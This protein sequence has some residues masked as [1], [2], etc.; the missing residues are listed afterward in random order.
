LIAGAVK[1]AL[2][3][4]TSKA[5]PKAEKPKASKSGKAYVRFEKGEKDG[6]L[7]AVKVWDGGG[8]RSLASL[9]AENWALIR[10]ALNKS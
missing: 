6:I 10:E 2:E 7:R 8:F 1:S 5:K 3:S 9:S 4:E